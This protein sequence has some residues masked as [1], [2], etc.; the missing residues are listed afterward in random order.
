MLPVPDINVFKVKWLDN[1]GAFSNILI[2][3]LS[4]KKNTNSFIYYNVWHNLFIPLVSIQG[5]QQWP[6]FL[7]EILKENKS[8][9]HFSICMNA[10]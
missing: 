7:G 3:K 10:Y 5:G 6:I 8:E 1:L 9:L 2:F 4:H